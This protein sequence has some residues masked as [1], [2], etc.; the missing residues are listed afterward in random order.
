MQAAIKCGFALEVDRVSRAFS[1]A[2][3]PVLCTFSTS[4]DTRRLAGCCLSHNCEPVVFA[5]VYTN[6][7]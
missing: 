5:T 2:V 7:V 3:E 1:K 6:C 4:E